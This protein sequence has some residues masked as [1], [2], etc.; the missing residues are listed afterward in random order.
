MSNA[1]IAIRP[2]LIINIGPGG[3]TFTIIIKYQIP[4]AKSR[5]SADIFISLYGL[6]VGLR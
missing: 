6:T 2:V 1:R 4:V 5:I 3:L